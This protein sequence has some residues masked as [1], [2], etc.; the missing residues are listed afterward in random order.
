MLKYATA[1][2]QRE[3]HLGLVDILGEQFTLGA[4]LLTL[5]S[6]SLTTVLFTLLED[7]S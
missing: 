4:I 3:H 2:R 1:A 5:L 6:I 7:T